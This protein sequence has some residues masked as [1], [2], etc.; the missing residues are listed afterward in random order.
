M[1]LHCLLIIGT[2]RNRSEQEIG[3]GMDKIY[4]FFATGSSVDGQ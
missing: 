1:F 2:P 4:I 3:L